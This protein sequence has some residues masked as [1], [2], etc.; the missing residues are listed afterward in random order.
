MADDQEL[1]RAALEGDLSGRRALVL[2]LLPTVQA[3]VLHAL[4]R[5]KRR[6]QAEQAA[7]DLTQTVFL[8]LFEDNGRRLRAW[9]AER[10]ASLLSFVGL[11]AE[12]EVIA[13]LRRGRRNPWTE[14]PTEADELVTR[15]GGTRDHESQVASRELLD[16]VLDRALSTLDD[17]GLLLFQRLV[18]DESPVDAVATETG[19][20]LASL[21]M[22][23]SRFSKLVRSIAEDLSGE[24]PRP[25][26]PRPIALQPAWRTR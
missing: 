24:P 17:R 7:P 1:L 10:G 20:T 26:P 8:V 16:A 19:S 22:W 6:E 3:R 4:L 21:Y 18:V 23:R 2:H 9:Q 25:P 11:V 13:H 15:V 14:S 5:Y 12:R